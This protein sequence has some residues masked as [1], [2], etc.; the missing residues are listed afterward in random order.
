M[1]IEEFITKY[2]YGISDSLQQ[3]TTTLEKLLRFENEIFPVEDWT[4][5]AE[6]AARRLDV[7]I[8]TFTG[9][10]L[11]SRST[12]WGEIF[13]KQVAD[14]T[15]E[16]KSPYR[17]KRCQDHNIERDVVCIDPKTKKPVTT[18]DIEVKTAL[19]SK[20]TSGYNQFYTHP[21][22]NVQNSKKYKSLDE[23]NYYLLVQ[24]DRDEE[25]GITFIG[26]IWFGRLSEN[27]WGGRYLKTEVRDSNCIKL[28]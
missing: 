19:K 4:D 13:D 1:V 6:Q 11:G 25:L 21:C 26:S 23:K 3:N 12:A 7:H 8:R 28:K 9:K 10:E 16:K 5:I 18:F 24:L 15:D 20:S 17:F 27:D 22:D 2:K 14:L